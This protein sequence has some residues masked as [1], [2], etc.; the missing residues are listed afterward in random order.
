M[1]SVLRDQPVCFP[2][3]KQGM[4]SKKRVI[5]DAGN[6]YINRTK[7]DEERAPGQLLSQAARVLAEVEVDHTRFLN[8]KNSVNEEAAKVYVDYRTLCIR[9]KD[10]FGEKLGYVHKETLSFKLTINA[11]DRYKKSELDAEEILAACNASNIR[12]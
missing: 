7:S 10:E 8:R 6:V 3:W 1:A 9:L 4:L 11:T 12:R 2:E 5:R